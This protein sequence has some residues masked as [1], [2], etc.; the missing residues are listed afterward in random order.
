MLLPGVSGSNVGDCAPLIQS[1]S[2]RVRVEHVNIAPIC[3][4]LHATAI[5]LAC[6]F[7][8]FDHFR[9]YDQVCY[10]RYLYLYLYILRPLRLM[11]TW[12][13]SNMYIY[14]YSHISIYILVGC[15]FTAINGFAVEV[16]QN[17]NKTRSVKCKQRQGESIIWLFQLL[18]GWGVFSVISSLVTRMF[19]AV[20]WQLKPCSQWNLPQLIEL[21]WYRFQLPPRLECR[22]WKHWKHQQL[23]HFFL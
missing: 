16:Q 5:S 10:N 7:F 1:Y 3:S 18:R 23:Q 2:G 4:H 9:S 17:S 20:D 19:G 15:R 14:I 8:G 11:F 13:S 12:L 22:C 6:I 21:R